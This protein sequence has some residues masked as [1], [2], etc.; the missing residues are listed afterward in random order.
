MHLRFDIPFAA[1]AEGN[2]C[3]DNLP[4]SPAVFILFS[5]PREGAPP[6]PYIGRTSDLRRRLTRLLSVRKQ[7]SRMLNLREVTSRIEYEPVGSAF[8]GMWLLYLLNRHYFARQ[9]RDRLR[10]KPPTLLKLKMQNRFP[11]CYP[12]RRMINDGSL[13]YGPFASTALAERFA[14]EFL[15]FFKIRRCVE[16]LNPDP[17]HPGCIYSQ[18]HM[19]LAPC[20]AGCTDADYQGEVQRVVEFL[21]SQGKSLLRNLESARDQASASMEFEQASKVHQKIEKLNDLLRQRSDLVRNLRD[22]HAV[23]VLPGAEAKAVV[24]FRIIAG[25][26]RGPVTLSLDENVPDP[27]PLDRQLHDLMNTLQEDAQQSAR[28]NAPPWEHLSLLA[29]WYYSSFRQGELVMLNPEQAIPH[30]RLI[31]ICRKIL[32]HDNEVAS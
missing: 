10:L 26:L 3:Q 20:F 19:C 11:R 13:Y 8:E 7:N 18:L 29:R 30:S 28:A 23:M 12:T 9:Y 2:G 17:S 5:A 22:L 16:D 21:D 27:K 31:R 25:E 4:A 24:F 6:A 32:A 15:D 14:G 1:D